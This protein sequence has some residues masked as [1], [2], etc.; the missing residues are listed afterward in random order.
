MASRKTRSRYK[1]EPGGFSRLTIDMQA[2]EAFHSL[3]TKAIRVL[4]YALY[5]NYNAATKQNGRSVFKFTNGIARKYLGMHQ[6]TF[7][8]AKS[9][10]ADKGFI[11]WERH[12]GLKGCNGVPSEFSLSGDWKRWVK[13][14][15]ASHPTVTGGS[16]PTVTGRQRNEA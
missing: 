1:G 5:L 15:R 11:R 16:H 10:L 13:K 7:T 3:S 9:E 12:G 14:Q 6:Q 8:R 4:L 2:S